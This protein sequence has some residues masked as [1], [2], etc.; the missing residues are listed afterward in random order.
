MVSVAQ[1]G[2]AKAL[3]VYFDTVIVSATV[4]SDLTTGEMAA[5][6]AS[7][8]TK[9]RSQMPPQSIAAGKGRHSS[10]IQHGKRR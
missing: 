8:R 5:V 6:Q 10:P 2:Q 7:A 4:M 9:R 3:K 1:I